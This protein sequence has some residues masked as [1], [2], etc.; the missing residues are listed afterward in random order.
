[1]DT[2]FEQAAVQLGISGVALAITYFVLKQSAAQYNKTF[3]VMIDVITANT[4]AMTS[5]KEV[6][7]GLPD[8]IRRVEFRL[9]DGS[10]QFKEHE[11]RLQKL[12]RLE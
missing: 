3:D 4:A 1:M 6:I 11:E 10:A 5:V 7:G 2:L 12:E 8:F 9:R